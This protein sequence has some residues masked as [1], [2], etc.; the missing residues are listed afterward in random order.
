M[1]ENLTRI[2]LTTTLFAFLIGC[3]ETEKVANSQNEWK[4][5]DLNRPAP[6]KINPGENFSDAPSNAIV[7]FDG[8]DF[9]E[10]KS[11][12]GGVKVPWK[13][14][15]DYMEVKP[16]SGSILT[17][18]KF[19][20]CQLHLEW[21]TLEKIKRNGQKSGNSGVFLMSQYE[22]QILDSYNNSTYP[23]GQAAAIYGQKPPLFNACKKPGKWQSYD[24]IFRRPRFDKQGDLL[25][26]A[27]ITVFHNGVLVHDH[28]ELKGKT[29]H[30]KPAKYFYHGDKMSLMLQDHRN[31]VRFRNIWLVELPEM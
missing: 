17:R 2:L 20:D 29:M 3:N 26:P 1:K 21:A 5:H 19:G 27:I 8:S 6:Q 9:S 18:K 14:E 24:I 25:K 4:V 30:E 31:L 22:V 28:Y 11:A 7:L 15:N 10:W 12:K 16:K 23:D 13:L